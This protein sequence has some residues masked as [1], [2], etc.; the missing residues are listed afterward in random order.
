MSDPT[1]HVSTWETR[2]PPITEEQQDQARRYVARSARD[3]DDE[4]LLLDALGLAAE[5]GRPEPPTTPLEP[6]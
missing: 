6:K 2:I 5:T 1:D 3:A 4:A